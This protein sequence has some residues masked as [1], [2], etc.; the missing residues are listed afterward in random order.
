MFQRKRSF[1]SETFLR[2]HNPTFIKSKRWMR[3][4]RFLMV[5][6]RRKHTIDIFC[7]EREAFRRYLTMECLSFSPQFRIIY[8]FMAMRFSRDLDLKY[9]KVNSLSYSISQQ[10]F[11]PMGVYFFSICETIS[12]VGSHDATLLAS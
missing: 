5:Q 1:N 7:K 10:H 11:N 4:P 6:G 3:R 2:I 9:I 12:S 8:L